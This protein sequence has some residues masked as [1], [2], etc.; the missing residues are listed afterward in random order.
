MDCGYL[1]LVSTGLR[2]EGPVCDVQAPN[3]RQV[4]EGPADGSEVIRSRSPYSDTIASSPSHSNRPIRETYQ[5]AEREKGGR[6]S[7]VG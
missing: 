2:C 7:E 1:A 4:R 5:H 3:G 6:K